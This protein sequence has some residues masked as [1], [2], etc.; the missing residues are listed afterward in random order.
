MELD[1]L[2]PITLYLFVLAAY[3]TAAFFALRW[4]WRKTTHLN[5]WVSTVIRSC[6]IAIFFAPTV[7]ACGA[8]AFV[9]FPILLISEISSEPN[10]CSGQLEGAY[11]ILIV[12]W[13]IYV[14]ILLSKKAIDGLRS[15]KKGW[16]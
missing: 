11:K 3:F 4:L 1:Q 16:L 15:K 13:I 9:P 14:A 7:F 12:S 6:S 10:A 2:L 5:F 8:A